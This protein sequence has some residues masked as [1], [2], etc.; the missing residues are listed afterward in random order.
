MAAAR[1][2]A[3]MLLEWSFVAASVAALM[4]ATC[5]AWSSLVVIVDVCYLSK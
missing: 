5:A 3:S 4:V 2:H 1:F